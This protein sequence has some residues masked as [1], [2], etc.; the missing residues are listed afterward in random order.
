[1]PDN[2]ASISSK[3][4]RKV[5]SSRNIAGA[6]AYYSADGM[7]YSTNIT[8]WVD[9]STNSVD[10]ERVLQ[11]LAEHL[12]TFQVTH[13]ATDT[14]WLVAILRDANYHTLFVGSHS[15]KLIRTPSGDWDMPIGAE[16]LKMRVVTRHNVWV[17]EDVYWAQLQ[18]RDQYG[19]LNGESYEVVDGW[20]RDFPDARIGGGDLVLYQNNGNQTVYDLR[21]GGEQIIPTA[22]AGHA[23]GSMDDLFTN[24]SETVGSYVL[25]P[26]SQNGYGDAKAI[27]IDVTTERTIH[28]SGLTTEG[29][30]AVQVTVINVDTGVKTV[31]PIPAGG[32]TGVK[33]SSGLNRVYMDWENGFD[34]FQ[35]DRYYGGPG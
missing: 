11:S 19:N 16:V 7:V 14:V 29:E 20:L 6:T 12:I 23:V 2:L 17:G 27:R 1:V 18:Y 4:A 13:P 25:R 32:T 30:R 34:T 35:S 15:F 26:I 22:V 31:M 3:A 33:M 10:P 9:I 5:E 21:N 8:P 24:V 28:F